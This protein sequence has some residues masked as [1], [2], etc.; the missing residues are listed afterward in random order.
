MVNEVTLGA[1]L[2]S[3]MMSINRTQNTIDIITE[4]LASG[5]EV[6]SAID[7]PK[8]FFVS[9]SL[10]NEASDSARL[11]DGINQSIRTIQEGIIG[12]EATERLLEQGEAVV[13]ESQKKLQTGVE[14]LAVF[15]KI[16]N[17]SPRSL[18]AQIISAAPDVYYRLNE[19]A[20]PIVDSG[21]G[22]AGP[23]AATYG[24]GAAPNA[25][26]TQTAASPALI[27]TA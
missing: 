11:L 8:N 12:L 3:T 2:R 23:V 13:L 21:F 10:K 25:G 22:G 4:R 9:R 20:G 26:S 17:V 1:A 24:G 19:T 5:L 6:N 7:D 15:E 18:D 27:S 14:D 16:F